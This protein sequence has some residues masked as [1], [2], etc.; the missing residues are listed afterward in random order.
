MDNEE[1]NKCTD[2]PRLL[3][4]GEC[5]REKQREAVDFSEQ[6]FFEVDPVLVTACVDTKHKTSKLPTPSEKLT[7][8]S[9]FTR[10]VSIN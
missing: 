8:C 3:P 5:N 10:S 4:L 1:K 7:N 6:N 2:S 9:T